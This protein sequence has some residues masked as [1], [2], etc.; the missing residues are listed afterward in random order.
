MHMMVIESLQLAIAKGFVALSPDTSL[1]LWVLFLQVLFSRTGDDF[2]LLPDGQFCP[3]Y[4][5]PISIDFAT[6]IPK[7][8][9][10]ETVNV[11]KL[12]FTCSY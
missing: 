3:N 6:S 2:H 9:I 8:G 1:P 10:S 12:S 4:L 7:S 11:G 5:L